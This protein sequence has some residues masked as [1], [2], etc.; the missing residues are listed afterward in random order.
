MNLKKR[1]DF[2]SFS[3][4][5]KHSR[6]EVTNVNTHLVGPDNFNIFLKPFER[7]TDDEKRNCWR[8]QTSVT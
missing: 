5:S 6:C 8:Q 3:I 2:F 4:D 1:T 7:E